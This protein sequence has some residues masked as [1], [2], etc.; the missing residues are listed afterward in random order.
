MVSTVARAFCGI[1]LIVT[2]HTTVYAQGKD[3]VEVTNGDR[4]TGDVGRLER[5][6]LAFREPSAGTISINWANV[7]SL[8]STQTLEVQLARAARYI[9]SIS[10]TAAGQIV[11]QTA[12]G[13]SPPIDKK[14]IVGIL[15]IGREL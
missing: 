15:P 11:V 13:P 5:G 3:V 7:V 9:G 4:F 6:R 8:T 14:D 12:A 2:L 10:T 1:A